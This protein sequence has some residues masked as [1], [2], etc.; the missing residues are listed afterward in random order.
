MH[1]AIPCRAVLASKHMKVKE[2]CPEC[3]LGPD[4]IQHFLF[5]CQRS[6]EV[7]R[8]LGLYDIIKKKCAKYK[9]GEEVVLELLH[10]DAS[11][12]NILGCPNL[13]EMVATTA[14]YLWFEHRKIYH[15]EEIQSA[16]RIA[17]AIRGL[18][19]N[20]TIACAHNAKIHSSGWEKPPK[21]Y[22][23][24]NVDAGFDQDLLQGSVGAIVRDQNGQFIAATNEKIE[25][26]YD[27]NMAEALAVRF[28]MNLAKT[29][30][31][32]KVVINSDNLE[33]VE[34]LKT[35]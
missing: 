17:L 8:Q 35:G 21:G 22:V 16:S 10:M 9:S 29:L 4:S 19:A 12:I 14:W 1:A 34:A 30:G 5:E 18:S 7:W 33:V 2:Q 15:G 3:K 11:E 24:L 23:K 31:C 28:G 27:L 26:S 13:R 25:I 32:S 6:C 20:F